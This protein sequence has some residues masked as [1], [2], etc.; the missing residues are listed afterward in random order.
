MWRALLI[1]VLVLAAPAAAS[2]SSLVSVDAP[3]GVLER[4]GLDV[5]HDG[6]VVL[7]DAR[8]RSLL[9]RSGYR[10]VT[11]VADLE[12][13][14]TRARRTTSR[15]PSALPTGRTAYRSLS[16]YEGELATL[17]LANPGLV[18][19]FELPRASADG[20]PIGAVEI[21]S[22]VN[23]T[24]DGR[25]EYAIFGLHHAREWPTGEV[26]MELAH[27]LVKS[28]GAPRVRAL[29][30]RVRVV[31]VPVVNP[32]GFV[33]SQ[34]VD[35][36][37]RKNSPTRAVDLNRNYGAGWGGSG[38]SAV[39]TE[40]T[41]RGP[42]PFSE[43]ES[44]AVHE[45]SQRRHFTNVQSVHNIAS[46]I[47]R[48]PGFD[49]YGTVARDEAR[50][51]ALG[52]AMGAATGY[53]SQKAVEFGEIHG[54]TEDWNYIAQGAFGYTI[55]LGSTGD[56][57][58]QGTY[59]THVV[60]QYG[61][62][63]EAL[64]LAGEQAADPADHGVLTGAASAGAML[65]LRRDFT[66][67]TL[68]S[69]CAAFADFVDTTLAVPANGRFEWHVGP[70]TRP[71]S[72]SPEAWTLTCTDAG[73]TER[74]R[75]QIVVDRGQ[76]VDV[77]DACRPPASGPGAQPAPPAGT[78]APVVSRKPAA[79][80]VVGVVRLVVAR[81]RVRRSTLLRRRA[82]VVPLRLSGGSLRDVRVSLL[83]ARR[84]VASRRLVRVASSQRVRLPLRRMPS[85]GTYRLRV[86][87]VD[88]AGRVVVA[89]AVVSV[90]R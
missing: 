73:G 33:F 61:G 53:G 74:A 17:A 87:G 34:E 21:A 68:C 75:R 48:Q 19:R 20:R 72:S 67:G 18:R 89:R 35:P 62:V 77:G 59:D 71:W 54:A 8:D 24:G 27:D 9:E 43:P 7:H 11:R 15:G 85:A 76:R 86:R 23:A 36:M 6:N 55:E 29:L 44:A 39:P 12:A 28:Y 56:G 51:K 70:S 57:T 16:D 31:I 66:T 26:V 84:V 13:V 58:F 38:S 83:R 90:V 40:P 64:L 5:T 47:L 81:Q 79:R 50:M 2:A 63:R 45:L 22:N 65:R 32:D 30:D 1:S 37:W 46:R 88:G 52:D 14:A 41:Y 3:A 78:P 82:L 69:G 49:E 42:S 25:P 4:L 60:S 80:G 10:F